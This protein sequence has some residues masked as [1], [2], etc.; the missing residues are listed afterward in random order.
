MICNK[1]LCNHH[2]KN[3]ES[4]VG[5][6]N[7]LYPEQKKVSSAILSSGSNPSLNNSFESLISSFLTNQ[8]GV[9]EDFLPPALAL[10]LTENLESLFAAGMFHIAG[11]GNTTI[12][13][14]K[15]NRSDVIHW[16]DRTNNRASEDQ[17]FDLMDEFILYLNA[18][19]YA[20]I[21]SYEFHYTLYPAGSFY[22]RHLDQFRN[23]DSRKFS[24]IMYLNIDWRKED[25]GE[26]RIYHEDHSQDIAPTN[27][28][29][30]FF[31]SGE[32]EHEVLTTNKARLSITGWLKG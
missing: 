20:G 14:E 29:I 10:R 24:M 17:F 12:D 9:A 25:G 30:V 15:L 6:R 31:R 26:L 7:K 28:K 11:T 18:S 4:F 22:K 2:S 21:R 16:L 23:N 5:A 32:L 13:R 3:L 8:V 27:G 19:C 1:F